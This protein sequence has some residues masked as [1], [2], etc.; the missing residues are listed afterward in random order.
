MLHFSGFNFM[1]DIGLDSAL[2]SPAKPYRTW[3]VNVLTKFLLKS[4]VIQIIL[5]P[6]YNFRSIC[7]L[8]TV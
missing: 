5:Y 6:Q 4:Y 7:V 2:P 3:R 8:D 1:T